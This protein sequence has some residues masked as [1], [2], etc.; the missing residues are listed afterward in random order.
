MMIGIV[1]WFDTPLQAA[2][3][4]DPGPYAPCPVCMDPLLGPTR[5]ADIKCISVAWAGGTARSYFFRVHKAC[6]ERLS[7]DEK[8]RLESSVLDCECAAVESLP[9]TPRGEADE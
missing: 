4:H 7:D 6:W 9:D 1:G 2:P 5:L 3:T 8:A